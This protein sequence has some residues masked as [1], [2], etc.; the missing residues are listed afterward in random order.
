MCR[1]IWRI[2][3]ID[4]CLYWQSNHSIKPTNTKID[5][6][7]N[8]ELR[9]N[10]SGLIVLDGRETVTIATCEP[11]NYIIRPT[12]HTADNLSLPEIFNLMQPKTITAN[13]LINQAEINQGTMQITF[14]VQTSAP[15]FYWVII[16]TI[17]S[18]VYHNIIKNRKIA[19][20]C[21]SQ[22]AKP[23]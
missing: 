2:L 9:H 3:S 17:K 15:S 22:W 6:I 20:A 21:L 4:V 12:R 7:Q 8:E 19:S 18:T 16:P 13:Q 1:P 14:T 23:W 5:R 11:I 10:K